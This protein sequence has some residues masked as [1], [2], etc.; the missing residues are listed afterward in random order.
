[1]VSAS[2][3]AVL[4]SAAYARD[5][6]ALALRK[7]QED[8]NGRFKSSDYEVLE[9]DKD[10]KVFRKVSTGDVIVACRGTSG[11]DDANPDL[12]IAGGVLP[13]HERS[14]KITDVV[15]KYRKSHD[16][17]TVTGHSLGGALAAAAAVR[18]DTMAVT[19][20]Q[21]SSPIDTI[22]QGAG[23]MIGYDYK[24]IVHFAVCNDMVSTS[25]CFVDNVT[26]IQVPTKSSSLSAALANH[27]L[28]QFLTLDDSKY[29]DV[30]QSTSTRVKTKQLKTPIDD[31]KYTRYSPISE[32]DDVEYKKI[33]DR[34]YYDIRSL[35]KT[36]SKRL[37]SMEVS[38]RLTGNIKLKW[39]ETVE[40]YKSIKKLR[41]TGEVVNL[42]N[43][44]EIHERAAG[45]WGGTEEERA[46]FL[47]DFDK[48]WSDTLEGKSYRISDDWE[49][50]VDPFEPSSGPI[51]DEGIGTGLAIDDVK[52]PSIPESD[53][54]N[55]VEGDIIRDATEAEVKEITERITSG[56]QRGLG[57][58]AVKNQLATRMREVG[59]PE[60]VIADISREADAMY[61]TLSLSKLLNEMGMPDLAKGVAGLYNTI[62]GLKSTVTE[63][64]VN[65]ARGIYTGINRT[66]IGG[67][68]VTSTSR[69]GKAAIGAAKEFWTTDSIVLKTLTGGKVLLKTSAIFKGLVEAVGWV[70]QIGFLIADTVKVVQDDAHIEELRMKIKSGD[71]ST[72]KLRWKLSRGLDFAQYMRR[73]DAIKAGA[74][75]VELFAAIIATIFAPEAAP[76]VWGGIAAQQLS[77]LGID[78]AYI[79]DYQR[80]YTKKYYG[81]PP[82]PLLYY[83]FRDNEEG[84]PHKFG[85]MSNILFDLSKSVQQLYQAG[86]ISNVNQLLSIRRAVNNHW[87]T[88][89]N[90]IHGA[91]GTEGLAD[92]S[93]EKLDA[94]FRDNSPQLFLEG[95]YRLHTDPYMFGDLQ[96]NGTNMESYEVYTALGRLAVM[97]K[98]DS[99]ED[100][101][102]AE[103]KRNEL[104]NERK[105]NESIF[106][107]H[108]QRFLDS[109]NKPQGDAESD[110]EYNDRI[111]RW[112]HD[113]ALTDAK[114]A[115]L[116]D[117]DA[118][119]GYQTRQPGE[120]V[121]TTGGT[122]VTTS[123]GVA[124][125]WQ[126]RR[127]RRKLDTPPASISTM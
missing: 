22:I 74:H 113:Q 84:R 16:N 45:V 52:L 29:M 20:N 110:E 55:V 91:R 117:F 67:K 36:I 53:A 66:Y 40:L 107:L 18:T 2:E 86:V 4:A 69:A 58:D 17:V 92:L 6:N 51:V 120:P 109:G 83:Q 118:F 72:A 105:M 23:K 112:V 31:E 95:I 38:R 126:P 82:N 78:P 111:D 119:A 25:A 102:Y 33:L 88:V 39:D 85:V 108:E 49:P 90:I 89:N 76:F 56:I 14:R 97:H 104:I 96:K 8:S 99:I 98:S 9:G 116:A 64:A 123:T 35:M 11:V 47:E 127:K 79:E 1:M 94:F 43:I 32:V 54:V 30:L 103:Q 100:R 81:D 61:N 34:T 19:F 115:A 57:I 87:T 44:T 5:D 37:G 101:M 93:Y 80:Q 71:P 13:L 125:V 7:I 60:E 68:L 48:V 50:P 122:P 27:R 3:Y 15:R 59:I 62:G 77:E 70:A 12:F 42:N 26:N 65:A 124:C 24:N 73:Y 28:G 75:G 46:M 21:G 121:T 114:N 63:N 106:K 41:E 10:Y